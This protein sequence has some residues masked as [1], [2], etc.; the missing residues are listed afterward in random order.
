M[1][2]ERSTEFEGPCLC[3]GGTFH[4]DDCSPDHGW[5]TATPQW[6][7]SSIR[8]P[9]CAKKYELERR[10]KRFV[11]IARTEIAAVEAKRNKAFE[12][13]R[14]LMA[15]ADVAEALDSYAAQLDRLPSAAARHR[16]LGADG[17]MP[18]SI[19]TFRKRWRGGDTWLKARARP[20]H[21]LAIFAA[22]GLSTDAIKAPLDE[23]A[24]L[25]AAAAVEP[26]PVGEPAYEL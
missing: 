2:T 3:G 12:A 21:L 19:A 11:L 24:Q 15:R 23:L 6:Y 5:P 4:I 1:G 26:A 18:D 17:F 14:A 13:G 8:C 7:E 16:R 22:I 20:G 10:G 9:R 25:D